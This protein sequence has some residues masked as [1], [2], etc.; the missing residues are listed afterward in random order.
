V[1]K[2]RRRQVKNSLYS[3]IPMANVLRVVVV[4]RPSR[5]TAI[6]QIIES[7]IFFIFLLGSSIFS[8]VHLRFNDSLRLPSEAGLNIF[9]SLPMHKI[10]V[11]SPSLSP[12]YLPL[13]GGVHIFLAYLLPILCQHNPIPQ[14]GITVASAS[15]ILMVRTGFGVLPD[16]HPLR[17]PLLASLDIS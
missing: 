17:K 12:S 11:E 8:S 16:Y 9:S 1:E 3:K 15:S 4:T 10:L 2:G 7:Q 6:V 14:G 13:P 5:S